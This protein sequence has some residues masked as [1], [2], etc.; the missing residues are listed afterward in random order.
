MAKPRDLQSPCQQTLAQRR[1]R[2]AARPLAQADSPAE[3]NTHAEP[4]NKESGDPAQ[5]TCPSL[6]ST[7]AGSYPRN[8][9][10]ARLLGQYGADTSPESNSDQQTRIKKTYDHDP[11]SQNFIF[12]TKVWQLNQDEHCSGLQAQNV[13]RIGNCFYECLVNHDQLSKSNRLSSFR[14][15]KNH[16][17][18]SLYFSPQRTLLTGSSERLI[19]QTAGIWKVHSKQYDASRPLLRL[20]QTDN[21]FAKEP[22]PADPPAITSPGLVTMVIFPH[23]RQCILWIFSCEPYRRA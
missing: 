5:Q 18:N 13:P 16:Y 20:L 3:S 19:P 14:A 2:I 22:I 8:R 9:S 6:T 15:V 17:S 10:G 11:G 23:Q 21:D 7:P 12:R 4:Q 1:T